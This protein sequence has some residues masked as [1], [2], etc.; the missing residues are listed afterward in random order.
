MIRISEN[1][2]EAWSLFRKAVFRFLFMFITSFIFVF[3]NGTFP[4]Y[5]YI[6]TPLNDLMHLVTPWFAKT[7]L[8]YTYDYSIFVNG[9]GDTSYAWVSLLLLITFAL[10]ASLIWSLTDS[11]RPHYNT[12]YYWLTV[13][14]RYY[15]A[16]MLI[17]YGVIKVMHAQM[18]PPTLTRLIQPLGEFSPMGLAWT[19]IGY[20]KYKTRQAMSTYF[21]RSPLYGIYRFAPLQ[22][23]V[24][25]IPEDWRLIIFEFNND[26]VLVRDSYYSPIYQTVII[27]HPKKKITL[28]QFQYDYKIN[29][30]G[31]ILLRKVFDDRVEEIKLIKQDPQ[32][33]ELLTHPFRWIQEFPHN[34]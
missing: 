30:N 9:S 21:S 19:F 10:A 22:K 29:Q 7:V 6:N 1:K 18:P 8:G 24:R 33:F 28:N 34:R 13:L 20:S 31:D 5:G 15:I 14:I 32:Q 27:D 17:N 26:H 3:N 12:L 25:T 11:K 23:A 4:L 2:S 16:F